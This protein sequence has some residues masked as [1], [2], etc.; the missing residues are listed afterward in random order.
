MALLRAF[1]DVVLVEV[2]AEARSAGDSDKPGG[3][4]EYRPISQVVKQIVA[5]VE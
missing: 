2:D 3:I 4:V 5:D 1:F